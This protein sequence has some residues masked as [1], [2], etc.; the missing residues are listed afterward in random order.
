MKSQLEREVGV[1]ACDGY[2]VLSNETIELSPQPTRIT[3]VAMP[4]SL[5]CSFGGD[6]GTA[7]NSRI[8]MRVW[9]KI[10]S[11]RRFL[12]FKWTVKLDPDAV[13][14]PG[15][16]RQHV[17]D[18]NDGDIL[19]IN[20]C[21]EGLHGP[22]EVLSSGGM[23]ALAL[24]FQRCNDTLASEVDTY[25]EDVWLRRCLGLLGVGRLD[26]YRLLTEKA[27]RPY[28]DPIPCTSGAASFHPLKTPSLYFQCLRDAGA[29]QA[30]G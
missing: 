2:T 30:L 29:D 19:Y 22:I 8:F 18:K 14:I 12:M 24:G 21:D 6:Y 15:R 23:K 1:F 5:Q 26:D 25:G 11:L 7:M 13:F 27:C 3:T 20:N 17:A 16:F 9:N 10:I 4:G 28:K